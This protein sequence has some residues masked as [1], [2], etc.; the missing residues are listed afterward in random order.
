MRD[1]RDIAVSWYFS[2]RYSHPMVTDANRVARE[3][4]EGMNFE[5]GM[6]YTIEEMAQWGVFEGL[7]SWVGADQKDSSVL[8]FRFEDL[9]GKDAYPLFRQLFAHCDIRLPDDA[10][11]QLLDDF[12]FERLSKG[13]KQGEED[14]MS[15]YRKGIHG[16][17]QHY[18]DDRIAAR[19][20]E[21]AAD[22]VTYL[23]YA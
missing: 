4:L 21:I 11:R 17:W 19:F 12:S 9:T 22:V 15:H 1:P 13:R 23:G 8:V 3:T 2:N 6:I 10:L 14:I 7:Q 18:F 5:D 20:D 16:D